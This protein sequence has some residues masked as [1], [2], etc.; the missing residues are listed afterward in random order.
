MKRNELMQPG[1]VVYSQVPVRDVG[2]Q[3]A[4]A[5]LHIVGKSRSKPS[6]VIRAFLNDASVHAATPPTTAS[7]AGD[8]TTYNSPHAPEPEPYEMQI[9]ISGALERL[10]ASGRANEADVS[11]V[12]VGL[13]DAPLRAGDFH[14]D[15]MFITRRKT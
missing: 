14:F 11:L 8:F 7:F 9:D 15:D 13:D 3:H 6:H 5:Y 12:L 2:G 1:V 10:D 4:Y